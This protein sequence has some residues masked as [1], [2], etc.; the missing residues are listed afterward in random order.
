MKKTLSIEGMTCGNCVHHTTE[1]LQKVNGVASV[2]VDL[3]EKSAVVESE[4]E[5][6]DDVLKNAVTGAGY[7]VVSIS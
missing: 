2:N 5:I 7:T 3:A 4:G 6:S 1:A